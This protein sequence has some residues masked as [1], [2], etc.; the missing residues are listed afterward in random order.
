MLNT[1]FSHKIMPNTPLNHTI[2]IYRE[3][4]KNN[5]I[6]ITIQIRTWTQK[7]NIILITIQIGLNSIEKYNN[8]P[9]DS[10]SL[11]EKCIQILMQ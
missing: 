10:N 7:N 5:I 4:N 1:W 3:L 6:D 11:T 8:T 9:Y 2:M